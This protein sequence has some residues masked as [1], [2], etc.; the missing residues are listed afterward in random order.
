MRNKVLKMADS[1]IK[2]NKEKYGD[3]KENLA[4]IAERWSSIFNQEV[5]ELQVILALID[6]KISRII[7]NPIYSDSIIDIAGYAA[8]AEPYLE[9]ENN[10]TDQQDE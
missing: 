4:V 2:D 6:L 1:I 10:K 7:K 3:S 9:F 5:S 8:L